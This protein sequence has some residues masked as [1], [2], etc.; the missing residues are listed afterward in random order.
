VHHAF[1][2]NL[3]GAK[4]AVERYRNDP[5]TDF[6]QMA[7]EITALPR[8]DAKNVNF[9][10]IYGAATNAKGAGNFTNEHAKWFTGKQTVYITEDNDDAGRAHVCKVASALQ[11][12]VPNIRVVRFPDVPEKEDVTWWL[13]HGGTKEGLLERAKNAPPA[14]KDY[15]KIIWADGEE[16]CG[17]DWLWPGRFALGKIGL[18]A[19]L[20]DLGKG[21]IAAFLTAAV[22]SALAFPCGEGTAPQGRVIWFN[23]EDDHRDT[24]IP[25]LVAAG[26]DLKRVAFV[27][28]ARVGGKDKTFNLAT[29]LALLRQTI[30]EIGDAVLIIIDPMSAYLG[31]GKVDGR[32]A[33]DV[34]GVLTPLK[35]M[36]EEKHVA[37]IGIAHFNKKHDVKSALLRVSDSIAYVAAARSVYAVLEDP[38]DKSSKLF[39]RAKVNIAA[40][41]VQGLRYRFGV[42]IV[43]YDKRLAKDIDAPFIQWLETVE[44][45]ANEALAAADG[46]TGEAKREA[47]D[48]LLERLTDGPVKAEDIL[49][50]A[51]QCGIAQVTLRR[52]KKNL[53]V[54]SFKER[55]KIGGDWMWELLQSHNEAR[56]GE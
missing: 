9:A 46:R 45:T 19:G 55:G 7:S 5:D 40:A 26:A 13:Q 18:V 42:K 28:S 31:V 41:S 49:E 39:I 4:E 54:R 1:I 34:R 24:V 27:N 11:G 33:T 37:L 14:A 38:G 20:P 35:A 56:Q 21:Q 22:T 43:G 2:R 10:K 17:I 25:R 12:I 50:E 51:K 52:A 29:D 36:V 48:F 6:H 8:K 32:S 30:E 53:R 47:E 44:M 15:L 23:A 3:P 16:M